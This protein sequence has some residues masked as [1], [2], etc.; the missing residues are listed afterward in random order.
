MSDNKPHGFRWGNVW[1]RPLAHIPG[2]GRVVGIAPEDHDG[3]VTVYVSEGGRSVRVF[4]GNR[5]ML[6]V[7]DE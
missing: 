5:E 6:E 3:G 2:R 1:V 7:G 4:R